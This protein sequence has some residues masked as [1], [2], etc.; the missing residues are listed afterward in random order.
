M[1]ILD[2]FRPVDTWAP[3]KESKDILDFSISLEVNAIDLYIKMERK[4]EA[5]EAKEVFQ[6]LSNQERN[7][8]KRITA[9]LQI[10]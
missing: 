8:L 1:G 3:D 6:V 4:A 10:D 7:H 9:A 2:Y 5:K